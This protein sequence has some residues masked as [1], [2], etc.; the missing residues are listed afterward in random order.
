MVLREETPR[1]LFQPWAPA[2]GER[3]KSWVSPCPPPWGL[4]VPPSLLL[5]QGCRVVW[6][7]LGQGWREGQAPP[8][9]PLTAS[10]PHLVGDRVL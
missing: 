2:G 10:T 8:P 9:P 1:S 6:D 7:P 4:G 5:S 3:T